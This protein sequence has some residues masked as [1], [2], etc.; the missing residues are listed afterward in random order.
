MIHVPPSPQSIGLTYVEQDHHNDHNGH[1]VYDPH[2]Y[3]AIHVTDV[4]VV[5]Q[6]AHVRESVKQSESVLGVAIEKIGAANL[7]NQER[8]RAELQLQA[9]VNSAKQE[10]LAAQ[11]HAS[12]LKEISDCCCKLEATILREACASRELAKEIEIRAV[13][14]E[15]ADA[16]MQ[17]LLAKKV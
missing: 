10:L 1:P 16:K 7:Q 3:N 14:D 8:I 12:L 5:E 9:S 13:R 15:L 6:G 17:L 4:R 11:N 2:L